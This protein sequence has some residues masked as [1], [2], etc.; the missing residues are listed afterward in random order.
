MFASQIDRCIIENLVGTKV[1]N[2]DVYQT[3]FTHRS[4]LQQY[5]VKSSYETLEFL[6]DA[7]L[8][9][10]I[11]KYLYD[12]FQDQ[13]EGFLTKIRTKIVRGKTLSLISK[14]L[15]LD[16]LVIMND[17]GM[18]NN[19]NQNP[20]IL[21]DVLEALIGAIYLDLGII[22]AKQFIYKFILSRKINF[23]DD[24]YKD[25]VMRWCQ[26]N[27]FPLP[28]YNVVSFNNHEFRVELFIC[29]TLVSSGTGKTKK[30]AEQNAAENV[31]KMN[32]LDSF[33]EHACP[34]D[35]QQWTVGTTEVTGMV[36]P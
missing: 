8:S 36:E 25:I 33:N 31:I 28:V 29:E 16:S 27:R 4:A 3:A 2:M 30:D 23:D 5:S 11:T 32:I 24:N 7:V 15:G 21:E 14:E 9:F 34:R 19:W 17:K 20:K 22:H 18:R 35:T 13:Q 6:G 10:V 26:S 1:N 12:T